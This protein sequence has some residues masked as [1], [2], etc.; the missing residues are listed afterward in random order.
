MTITDNGL[1]T[2]YLQLPITGQKLRYFSFNLIELPSSPRAMGQSCPRAPYVAILCEISG[3]S[4]LRAS[5]S[6]LSTSIPRARLSQFRDLMAK[7]E[8]A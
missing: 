8:V 7:T 4:F 6:P 3:R 5:P 2:V 1:L